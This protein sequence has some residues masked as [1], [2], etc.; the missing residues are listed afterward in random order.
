MLLDRINSPQ[1]LKKLAPEQLPQLASQIRQ[2][3]I[4]VVSHTGGHLA[5]SLGAVELIIALHYSLDKPQDK[6]IFDMG[7]QAY[8]HKINR[9]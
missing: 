1:D 4:E 8:T 9:T 3:I 6:I 2:R 7:H 5:S